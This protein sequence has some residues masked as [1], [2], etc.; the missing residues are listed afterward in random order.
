MGTVVSFDVRNG[1]LTE[2]A[3]TT[4]ISAACARLHQIDDVFSTW[5]AD[6]P[7]S[8]LR[9]GD[10]ALGD[11]PAEVGDVLRLCRL[12]RAISNGYF[13]PWA[14]PGGVD[15]T[16]LVKGWAAEQALATLRASGASAAM[17]NAG[18]DIAVYGRGEEGAWRIGVT[19]PGRADRLLCV[20]EVESAIAT[21]GAYERGP[22]IVDPMT[23]APATRF[24]SA[25]V[26]G[27]S[28]AIADALATALVA[29][30]GEVLKAV[31]AMP[32][33]AACVLTNEGVLRATAGF[34]VE[35]TS[36]EAAM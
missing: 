32:T 4:A 11:A 24:A 35:E 10:I 23:G 15:P 16:G 33:Y 8:R 7:V 17:V 12:A 2:T 28:L 36:Q 6:S 9:R 14:M 30:G 21:S 5:K 13:D 26:V 29:G 19:E 34:P 3:V 20:V 31:S 22:H 25:T 1:A 27:P 18:G